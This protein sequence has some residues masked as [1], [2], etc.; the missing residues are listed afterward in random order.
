MAANFVDDPPYSLSICQGTIKVFWTNL[1]DKDV[2]FTLPTKN[3]NTDKLVVPRG[4]SCIC[5]CPI[6]PLAVPYHIRSMELYAN[7]ANT[8]LTKVAKAGPMIQVLYVHITSK[9]QPP[10]LRDLVLTKVR[11]TASRNSKLEPTLLAKACLP[12]TLIKEIC[13]VKKNLLTESYLKIPYFTCEC[14][15]KDVFYWS[16][17]VYDLS[18]DGETYEK[19]REL[20]CKFR[21]DRYYRLFVNKPHRYM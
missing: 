6:G 13:D 2:T 15:N 9:C 19:R 20:W 10:S 14:A 11:E 8:I 7:S 18:L 12:H 17:W 16:Q 4:V 3:S 5:F 21:R 1:T